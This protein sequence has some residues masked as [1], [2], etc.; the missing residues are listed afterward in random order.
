M[1]FCLQEWFW[2]NDYVPTIEQM[3]DVYNLPDK[4]HEDYEHKKKFLLW[5]VDRYLPAAAGEASYGKTVRLYYMATDRKNIRGKERVLVE[6]ASEA[7][8]WLLLEN[9]YEKWCN[10]CAKKKENPGWKIPKNKKSDPSTHPYNK[11]KWTD[12][13]AGQGGGWAPGARMALE[14]NKAIVKNIRQKDHHDGWKV[15]KFCLQLI[16]EEHQVTD[17]APLPP[18]AKKCKCPST[19]KGPAEA[20]FKE[21]DNDSDSAFSIHSEDSSGEHD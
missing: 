20:D 15:H 10:I 8:G 2:A 3:K 6:S 18:G 11:C 12:S 1:F 9:C 7:F 17:A 16:R 21:I 13:S 14:T 5:Y 4:S 19:K